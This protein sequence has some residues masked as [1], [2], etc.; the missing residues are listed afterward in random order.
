MA[1]Q[2]IGCCNSSTT[3]L[4]VIK[5]HLQLAKKCS[6]SIAICRNFKDRVG[7]STKAGVNRFSVWGQMRERTSWPVSV[8]GSVIL[9]YL[10]E[11]PSF[12]LDFSLSFSTQC[13]CFQICLISVSQA[14]VNRYYSCL[15]IRKARSRKVT[16]ILVYY[17]KLVRDRAGI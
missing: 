10:S 16:Y 2:I 17:Y 9:S 3:I 13:Q 12:S 11:L 8:Y 14:Y 5:A 6:S 1:R 4:L 15:Q 7:I